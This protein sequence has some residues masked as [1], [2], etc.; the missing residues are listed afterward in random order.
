[1]GLFYRPTC[2]FLLIT[3]VMASLYHLSAGDGI[4][5]AS[6]A[7]EMGIVFFGLLFVGPGKYSLDK[8]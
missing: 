2:I 4:A 8:R 6:R 7:M 5:V 1:L 3:M